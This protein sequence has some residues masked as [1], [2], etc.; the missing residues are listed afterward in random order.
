MAFENYSVKHG[1]SLRSCLYEHFTRQR[2]GE[3]LP[4]S[5]GCGYSQEDAII[6]NPQDPV[7]NSVFPFDLV[8][9]EHYIAECRV[10]EELVYNRE[11]GQEHGFTKVFF[12]KQQLVHSKGRLFDQLIVK[13]FSI[14]A[15]DWQKI[16]HQLGP[17][18][19]NNSL[20]VDHVWRYDAEVWFD[21]TEAMVSEF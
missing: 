3:E 15:C 4:I 2:S 21:V 8:G 11:H 10:Y 20:L 14:K 5:G 13:V 19:E 6:I 16:R 1:R 18:H 9:M 7:V 12:G 17:D